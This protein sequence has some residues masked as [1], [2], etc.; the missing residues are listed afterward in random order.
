MAIDEAS[1]P[2]Q[3]HSNPTAIGAFAGAALARAAGFTKIATMT[4]IASRTTKAL[5]EGCR[6][7]NTV[8]VDPLSASCLRT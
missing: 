7:G 1:A 3:L 8:I 4:P 5:D 2:E 6:A